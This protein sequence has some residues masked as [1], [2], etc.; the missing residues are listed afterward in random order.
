MV[1]IN[2]L[3]EHITYYERVK[4]LIDGSTSTERSIRVFL[5]YT[6]DGKKKKISRTVS[7]NKNGL[8]AAVNIAV[9]WLSEKT[10]SLKLLS[11]TRPYTSDVTSWDGINTK[12]IYR[13]SSIIVRVPG[14]ERKTFHKVQIKEAASYRDEACK[15]LGIDINKPL[16]P[17]KRD[18]YVRTK[19]H[20]NKNNKSLPTGV[21]YCEAKRY[22]KNGNFW[23]TRTYKSEFY[24]PVEGSEER[25]CLSISRSANLYGHK[26][27]LRQV[28]EWRT[29]M[30]EKYRPGVSS[31][32]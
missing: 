20:A 14:D 21:Y 31:P 16:R 8:E 10:S 13:G 2:N 9:D 3:P 27:A 7:V 17:K 24:A 23:I 5:S 12:Y 25:K 22:D 32:R 4:T 1:D 15:R 30:I 6:E 19:P 18:F 11:R 28:S 29:K 26:E